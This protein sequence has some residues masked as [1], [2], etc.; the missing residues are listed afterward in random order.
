MPDSPTPPNG[1]PN[2]HL[3]QTQRTEL[4]A[5]L[6]TP[7]A[8]TAAQTIH[9]TLLTFNC[10]ACHTRDGWGGVEDG[11][12]VRVARP[13]SSEHHQSFLSIPAGRS[14]GT[15]RQSL[16]ILPPRA[17]AHFLDQAASPVSAASTVSAADGPRMAVWP[18]GVSHVAAREFGSGEVV[19][20]TGGVEDSIAVRV[21]L[22]T[23]CKPHQSLLS[24]L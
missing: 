13:T 8:E 4:A 16:A 7:P 6:T 12:A 2:Y 17:R 9:R 23:M 15:Y 1:V 10:Y 20:A 18:I 11:I 19:V 21:V 3:S 24:F 22:S 5:A 14:G